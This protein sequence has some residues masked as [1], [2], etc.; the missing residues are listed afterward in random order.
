MPSNNTGV[1]VRALFDR[2]PGK[3]GHLMSPDGWRE[4]W[5]EYALDNG[6]FTAWKNGERWKRVGFLELV[7]KAVRL[8]R[9]PRW[10]VVPD[11]VGD[12]RRTLELW[13][14]WAT[15]LREWYGFPLAFACQD[16]MQ[17]EDVPPAADVLFI[18]GTT[19][20]KWASLPMW[21]AT[22][23]RV[24]VGRVNS[25]SALFRCREL[26]VESIDGTGWIRGGETDPKWIGL[27][28]FLESDGATNH[29]DQIPLLTCTPPRAPEDLDAAP[30]A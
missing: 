16:G 28:A 18:G 26:G 27:V 22:G 7:E 6:A 23:R 1:A 24:H 12:R 13:S 2:F 8:G 25:P 14:E 17:P 5:G 29:R 30:L 15:T 11:A 9:A 21:C 19:A 3:I 4:P 20:W 10:I